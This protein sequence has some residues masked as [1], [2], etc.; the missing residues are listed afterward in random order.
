MKSLKIRLEQSTV[1]MESDGTRSMCTR[2]TPNVEGTRN[3]WG[4][5][6]LFPPNLGPHTFTGPCAW[7]WCHP[8]SDGFFLFLCSQ[9]CTL[10]AGSFPGD[11]S[12]WRRRVRE[13]VQEMHEGN[14]WHY[15]VI[16]FCFISDSFFFKCWVLK[17]LPSVPSLQQKPAVH[18]GIKVADQ[19][20]ANCRMACWYK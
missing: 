10:R 6:S 12:Q 17:Y 11:R 19:K 7:V 16:D 20:N 4:E 18:H 9:M 13:H 1:T 15:S 3:R 2:V 8:A 5:L 14:S